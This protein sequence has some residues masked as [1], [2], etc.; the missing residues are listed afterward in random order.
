VGYGDISAKNPREFRI[1]TIC[2]LVSSCLWA[3]IIG[4]ACGVVANQD[5]A[6][7]THHQT[8]D[9]LNFFLSEHRAD[10]S[11]K[12]RGQVGGRRGPCPW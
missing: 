7:V 11:P 3:Y 5:V 8:L 6:T 12:L 10:F 1:S 2:V 9:Q 4:S